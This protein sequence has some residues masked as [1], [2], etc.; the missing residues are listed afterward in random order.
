MGPSQGVRPCG[1][2]KARHFSPGKSLKNGLLRYAL[3]ERDQGAGSHPP[4]KGGEAPK[5][6]K[7]TRSKKRNPPPGGKRNR[8][9]HPAG[10][11]KGG[12]A[13]GG[14]DKKATQK[15]S[16][17]PAVLTGTVP[18]WA[19]STAIAQLLG[20]TTR[21]IQ[22]LTQDGIL[23][24]EVPPG[25]GARKYRTCDTIQR[26]IDHVERKAQEIG[27]G[28]RLAELNLKK[29]EAEVALKES[30]GSLH[31]LKTAI[32]EGKYLPAEQATEE[33]AEFMTAFQKFAMT[34]PARMAGAM[35]GY[36]DAI[37]IRNAQKAIRKE[38]ETMLTAYV[39][40]MQVED[41]PGAEP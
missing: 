31:R 32:A 35:S 23:K 8:R 25:G 7:E 10:G 3:T 21:R 19:N 13:G 27:E 39:D 14:N 28:G 11:G 12:A 18:E 20:K 1:A 6:P 26:Y 5:N 38:L 30:Q 33:L 24:T 22:Q 41:T 4:P 16:T 34:I 15:K 9:G 2:R 40:A 29:L 17:A 37:T 36:A